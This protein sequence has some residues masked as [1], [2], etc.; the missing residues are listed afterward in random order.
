M[1]QAVC[2]ERCSKNIYY[3][4][5]AIGDMIRNI[6]EQSV[7]SEDMKSAKPDEMFSSYSSLKTRS[8]DRRQGVINEQL[9]EQK[10]GS[11]KERIELESAR[12][13]LSRRRH[14]ERLVVCA[15]E[16]RR[17]MQ[18]SNITRMAENA[19]QNGTGIMEKMADQ[20][21]SILKSK[22]SLLVA[23]EEVDEVKGIMSFRGKVANIMSTPNIF[24][25]PNRSHDHD[26][27]S[28]ELKI[29]HRRSSSLPD[30]LPSFFSR[31]RHN[32]SVYQSGIQ[33]L[34]KAFDTLLVQQ[35]DLK[36][37]LDEDKE[38]LDELDND[39]DRVSTKVLKQSRLVKKKITYLH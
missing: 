34:N 27:A 5:I 37:V 38:Q 16:K 21:E 2:T 22:D 10:T 15:L 36:D 7:Q 39:V 13:E 18:L 17:N 24:S 8:S 1:G 6:S 32:S 35:K 19:I 11:L 26:D 4:E 20:R 31:D 33:K 14:R 25:I 23:E 9:L 30:L 12:R 29:R 3:D 28:E